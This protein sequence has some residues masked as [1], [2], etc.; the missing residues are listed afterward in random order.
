MPEREPRV[1]F[2]S[3]NP[4]LEW[5]VTPLCLNIIW[6]NFIW[7]FFNPGRTGCMAPMDILGL[8]WFTDG[9]EE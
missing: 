3:L 6:S 7:L 9:I 1:D 4:F 2:K 8:V 5:E